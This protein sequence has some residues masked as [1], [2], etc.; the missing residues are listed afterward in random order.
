MTSDP[1]IVLAKLG[2]ALATTVLLALRLGL[3]WRGRAAWLA[4]TRD[5]LLLALGVA[6]WLAWWDFFAFPISTWVHEHD[7]FHY[8]VGARYFP[9]LGY[10]GIYDCALAADLDGASDE[11]RA[12][13]A[14]VRIRNLETNT[15]E[16]SEAAF[17]RAEA[18]RARFE[19]ER[20][21]AFAADVGWFRARLPADDWHRVRMDHGFN[22]SPVWLLAGSAL[23]EAAGGAERG[24]H[25]ASRVDWALLFVMWAGIVLAFGW[26]TACVAAVFWGTNGFAGFVWTGGS[27]LR[28]DWLVA[29]VLGIACLRRGLPGTAGALL[30]VTTLLRVFPGFA[31]AALVAKAIQDAGRRGSWRPARAHARFAAGALLAVL[32]LAPLAAVRAGPDA[33]G[34]FLRNSRKHLATPLLNHMGMRPVLTFDSSTRARVLETPDAVDPHQRWKDTQRERFTERRVLFAALVGAFA[35]LLWRAI[36]PLDDWAVVALGTGAIPI[37]ATLTTYYHV[38]LLGLALVWA[39]REI[40]GVALCALALAT[41]WISV[42]MPYADVPFVR[43]SLAEIAAVLLVTALLAREAG[44]AVSAE[45]DGGRDTDRT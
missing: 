40:A 29:L 4:R 43:M 23:A 10:T 33:W 25:W 6:G 24:F 2:V 37:A 28:Q 27:L 18:C 30:A 12:A 20:W 42:T 36:R 14:R 45:R 41:Q 32:L 19:P 35:V 11:A 3:A 13:L 8:F 39:H 21:R 15:L 44:R 31:A 5:A 7:A 26:R 34:G 16:W 9:E 17:A 22:G 1:G 38:A